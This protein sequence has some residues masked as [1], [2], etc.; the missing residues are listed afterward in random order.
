M[1]DLTS[2]ATAINCMYQRTQIPVIDYV[3]RTS[4]ACYVDMIAEPGPVRILSEE[5][6]SGSG[7]LN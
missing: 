4:D 6:E 7:S 2:F 1:Q 3:R 5:T